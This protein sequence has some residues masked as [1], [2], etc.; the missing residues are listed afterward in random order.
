[1]FPRAPPT[2]PSQTTSFHLIQLPAPVNC[3]GLALSPGVHTRGY[4]PFTTET[5]E[6]R[7][8]RS[9]AVLEPL[10]GREP[11]SVAPG[12]CSACQ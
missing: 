12:P 7:G 3:S 11:V 10:P 6:N 8:T 1:M 9:P 5:T 2:C 4:D